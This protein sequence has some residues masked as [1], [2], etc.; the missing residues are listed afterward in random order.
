[1]IP[2][3][4]TLPVIA[5]AVLPRTTPALTKRSER[6]H[7]FS[8]LPSNVDAVE[9][10]MM[11]S[12]GFASFVALIGPSG[13][14]KTQLTDC[15]QR[16]SEDSH[17]VRVV[18][19]ADPNGLVACQSERGALVIDDGQS[20]FMSPRRTHQL[21]RL[22]EQRVRQNQPT[23][24]CFAQPSWS[25][26]L[27]GFIPYN[28]TW[29]IAEI[30]VPSADERFAVALDFSASIGIQVD[31]RILKLVASRIP[32]SGRALKGALHRLSLVSDQWTTESQVLS[33]CGVL[34]PLLTEAG[35]DLRDHV[36]EM[37]TSTSRDFTVFF[38]AQRLGLGEQ[39]ISGFFNIPAGSVYR[40]STRVSRLLRTDQGQNEIRRLESDFLASL[41]R[42]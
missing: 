4:P 42:L 22:L 40:I 30:A 10:A 34:H 8:V 26:R 3:L 38:M 23:V 1:M 20:V 16:D 41:D 37:A 39:D 13:W 2:T 9:T 27:K 32:G 7:R 6:Y 21:R 14:G 35:W 29:R 11:F 31:A 19:A 36:A 12:R 25:P 17:P 5:P 18:S 33:A 28:R 24:I 15:I